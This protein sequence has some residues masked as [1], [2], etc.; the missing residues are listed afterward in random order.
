MKTIQDLKTELFIKLKRYPLIE[1]FFKDSLQERIELNDSWTENILVQDILDEFFKEDDALHTLLEAIAE[2]SQNYNALREKLTPKDDY[3]RKIHDALAEL[4]GYYHL[5]DSQFKDI[6]AVSETLTQ[7]TPDFY[8]KFGDKEYIFEVKNM[9]APVDLADILIDK[10]NERKLFVP[11]VYNCLS[12]TIRISKTWDNI[13]FTGNANEVL[14]LHVIVWLHKLFYLIESGEKS[15]IVSSK[16]FSRKFDRENLRIKCDVKGN[17]HSVMIV[18]EGAKELS[19]NRYRKAVLL[20]FLNKALRVI[21]L[22]MSQLFEFDKDNRYY[23]YV[24]LNW[25]VPGQFIHFMEESHSII[26][27]VD[28]LVKN[29]CDK[30]YVRLLNKDT[31]P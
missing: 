14:K 26:K 13:D 16:I 4:N 11:D 17:K 8:G 28:S 10:I 3:D 24:L 25:H 1:R 30:L 18:P 23:K 27:I 9:R 21:D 5:K 2:D 19:S 15:E 6:K 29:I 22:G 12:F 7:K 20:P 31:L